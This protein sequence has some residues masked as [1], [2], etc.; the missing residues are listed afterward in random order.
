M[1]NVS[2]SATSDLELRIDQDSRRVWLGGDLIEL[3]RMEFDLLVALSENPHRV[4][5]R[6]QLLE[7][8]WEASSIDDGRPIEVYIHRLRHKL[9]ESATDPRYIQTVR[10]VG[11]RFEPTVKSTPNCIRVR[12]DATGTIQQVS[13]EID[14]AL[15]WSREEMIGERFMFGAQA[16][17]SSRRFIAFVNSLAG[18]LGLVQFSVETTVFWKSGGPQPVVV[19]VTFLREDGDISG[20]EAEISWAA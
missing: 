14:S 6:I 5:T 3:T 4:L 19:N 15:G 11:Y 1:S 20:V 16:P 18:R 9:G 10:G 12:Y 17:F 8:L 7:E 2:S 13:P